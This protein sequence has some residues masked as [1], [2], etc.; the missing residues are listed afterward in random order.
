V[1]RWVC[2]IAAALGCVAVGRDPGLRGTRESARKR[3]ALTWAARADRRV[4][5]GVILI[6]DTFGSSRN[7]AEFQTGCACGFGRPGSSPI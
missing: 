4:H 2:R 6:I 3:H 1:T 5:A 7:L